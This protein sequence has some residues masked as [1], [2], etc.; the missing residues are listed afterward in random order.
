MVSGQASGGCTDDDTGTAGHSVAIEHIPKGTFSEDSPV[1]LTGRQP[2]AYLDASSA[3]VPAVGFLSPGEVIP[4][5]ESCRH[6][7]RPVAIREHGGYR[8]ASENCDEASVGVY[9]ADQGTVDPVYKNG[10]ILCAGLAFLHELVRDG[11]ETG[12]V[13]EEAVPVE[14]SP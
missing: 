3:A 12:Y 10:K 1:N 2:R 6:G 14:G 13:N 4:D 11:G 7:S 8:I 9:P 5:G